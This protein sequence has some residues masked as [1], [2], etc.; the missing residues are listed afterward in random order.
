ME[1]IMKRIASS[2]DG[3]WKFHSHAK[4]IVR[5]TSHSVFFQV[6][7]VR[8]V[9]RHDCLEAVVGFQPYIDPRLDGVFVKSWGVYREFCNYHEV[10][11]LQDEIAHNVSIAID[12]AL[13]SCLTSEDFHKALSEPLP[14]EKRDWLVYRALL[15]LHDGEFLKSKLFLSKALALD[16]VKPLSVHPVRHFWLNLLSAL[17][18]VNADMVKEIHERANQAARDAIFGNSSNALVDFPEWSV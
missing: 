13:D 10:K 15:Y 17:S 3:T 18:E 8:Y 4:K 1:S 9:K 14:N 7:Y 16:N 12:R 5:E 6:A 11:E 2:S